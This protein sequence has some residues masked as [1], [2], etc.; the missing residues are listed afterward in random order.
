VGYSSDISGVGV[1]D[2]LEICRGVGI[3]R[4]SRII[5][6][7]D[8][9][10]GRNQS[11]DIGEVRSRVGKDNGRAAQGQEEKLRD[12]LLASLGDLT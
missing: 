5:E 1:T 4:A 10:T 12:L 8:W 7:A 9:N 3:V 11:R 2:T 6:H